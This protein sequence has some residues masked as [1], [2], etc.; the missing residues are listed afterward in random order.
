MIDANDN[1]PKRV[2]GICT[3]DS[4]DPDHGA[5]KNDAQATEKTEE[6][7]CPAC[8]RAFSLE[9][10]AAYREATEKIN[11]PVLTRPAKKGKS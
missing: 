8:R 1:P 9:D 5:Q 3:A 11:A 2:P 7:I 10:V 4:G 6:L